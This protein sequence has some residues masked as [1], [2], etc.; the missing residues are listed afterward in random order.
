MGEKFHYSLV[1][2]I[3]LYITAAKDTIA[4]QHRGKLSAQE[5]VDRSRLCQLIG[6]REGFMHGSLIKMARTCGKA[7]CKCQTQE[8]KHESYYIGQTCR[9]NTRMQSVPSQLEARV[10]HW[11]ANYK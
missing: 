9:R 10:R 2:D 1:S 11:V 8:A 6:N 5:R 3:L 4:M 7:T